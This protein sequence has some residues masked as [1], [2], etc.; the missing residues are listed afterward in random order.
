MDQKTMSE[1]RFV[2]AEQKNQIAKL[3]SI[4]AQQTIEEL[5]LREELQEL[6]N[7]NEKLEEGLRGIKRVFNSRMSRMID[8]QMRSHQQIIQKLDELSRHRQNIP[9]ERVSSIVDYLTRSMA[10]AGNVNMSER[11]DLASMMN[12]HEELIRFNNK[13][14]EG[15]SRRE[16]T[17][18]ILLR[19]GESVRE[20][21]W[22][23]DSERGLM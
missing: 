13:F 19:I 15:V 17:N 2:I 16:S 1:L 12:D 18:D 21:S 10:M 3:E 8:N 20:M 7:R 23:L 9:M 22:A 14:N 5:S 4:N 11:P 6:R